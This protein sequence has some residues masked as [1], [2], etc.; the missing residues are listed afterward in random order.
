MAA[1]RAWSRQGRACLWPSDARPPWRGRGGSMTATRGGKVGGG[2]PTTRV[3]EEGW[4]RQG[5][6]GVGGYGRE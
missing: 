4:Q 3:G 6:E 1:E 2:G 5:D